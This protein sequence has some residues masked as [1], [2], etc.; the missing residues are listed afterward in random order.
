MDFFDPQY[1]FIYEIVAFLCALSI[2][3]AP[4]YIYHRLGAM[5]ITQE[6][7]LAAIEMQ[8]QLLSNVDRTLSP[9]I[10]PSE[11]EHPSE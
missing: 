8:T 3:T 10:L 2:I 7:L 6:K 5:K 4:L 9:R 11:D 1:F